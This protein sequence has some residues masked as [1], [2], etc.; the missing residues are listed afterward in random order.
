VKSDAILRLLPAV[1]QRTALPG[2]PLLA[3]LDAM[4]TLHAKAEESLARW[5]A[6][7]DAHRTHDAFVPFLAQ[8]VGLADLLERAP[9]SG[10]RGEPFSPGLGRLRGLIAA[11]AALAKWRG[12][13]RGL[14]LFLETATGVHGFTIEERVAGPDRQPRPFHIRV[15]APAAALPH[16]A[17]VEQIVAREK[18]AFVTCEITFG[19]EPERGRVSGP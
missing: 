7:L 4:E 2:S 18:P 13:A 8:W 15:M 19:P 5:D 10:G 17:L 16:R 11:A 9:A 12:T 6:T 14:L 1:F 3:V